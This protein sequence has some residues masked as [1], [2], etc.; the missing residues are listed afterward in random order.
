MRGAPQA[1]GRARGGG[2]ARGAARPGRGAALP[3][4]GKGSCEVA[5][6]RLRCLQLYPKNKQRNDGIHTAYSRGREAVRKQRPAEGMEAP[7]SCSF[8]NR[9]SYVRDTTDVEQDDFPYGG[10]AGITCEYIS[11]EKLSDCACI[12]SISDIFNLSC[13]EAYKNASADYEIHAQPEGVC[14]Y[15]TGTMGTIGISAAMPRSEASF[16][17]ELPGAGGSEPDGKDPLTRS[18]MSRVLLRHFSKG[19]LTSTWQLIECETI[20][21]TSLTESTD[22][23]T[24][25]L[26]T[27]KRVQG[28]LT[29]EQQAAKV[30]EH[31]LERLKAV[32]TGGKNQ[33]L[34][35]ENELVSKTSTSTTAKIGCRQDN[36][37][38]INEYKDTR[39]FQNTE[40]ERYA[41]K[42][43]VRSHELIQDQGEVQRCQKDNHEV[44]SEMK[45]PKMSENN[46]SVPTIEGTNSF[47]TLLNKLATIH[48]IPENQNCFDSTEV[49]NQK[50][51]SIPGLSQQLKILHQ[52][53]FPNA[54]FVI[55]SGDTGTSPDAFTAGT[56]VLL[57]STP[58][59]SEPR[60]PCRTLAS[61]F[62]A[63]GTVE[64][65]SL[66]PPNLLPEITQGEKRSQILKEQTDQLKMK[67]EDFSQ[68]MAQETFLLQDDY[69]ALNELKRHLDALERNYLTAR[70]EHRDLQL[71]YYKDKAVSIGEFDPERKVEGEIFRLGTLLAAIR[72]Q[73]D[74]SKCS[75]APLLPSC[76]S[77]H[78]SYS[79]WESSIVS[80]IADSPEENAFLP[81]NNEGENTSQTSYVIPQK[82]A[83]FSS[84]RG[85]CNPCFHTLHKRAESTYERE[86]DP[87]GKRWLLASKCSSNVTRFFS[88]EGKYEAE[89]LGSHTQGTLS[90]KYNASEESMKGNNIQETKTGIHSIFTERK[91]TDLSDT[92]LSSDSEDISAYHSY[93]SQSDE[94]MKCESYKIFHPRLHRERKGY[95]SRCPRESQSQFKLRN[96]KESVQSCALC[97]N[98]NSGSTSCS[99]KRTPSQKAQTNKQSP[100]VVNRLSESKRS[101][102]SKSAINIRNRNAKDFNINQILNS[103]LDHAIQT[104]NS[105]KKATE[106]MVQ[107]VSEDLAKAARKQL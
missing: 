76:G 74:D 103:T 47:P 104:A 10:D 21:E 96:Y 31:H 22:E 79:L 37:Q 19:E 52:S 107:A 62:P 3:D 80:S 98:K 50:E 61:A 58:G 39:I 102:R 99:Q 83:H 1:A 88:P 68:R 87:L 78:S 17:K 28:P 89:G 7:R 63:A 27:C 65:R 77:A 75:P 44:T 82:N 40:E 97:R 33:N 54:G 43:S 6:F 29:R 91:P 4:W 81:K 41:F 105:L 85:K 18:K 70:E 59:L 69:L 55:Y 93:G 51:T 100:E 12:K 67:V 9:L 5:S 34:L 15:D 13:S 106:R 38:L 45:V 49:A 36:P 71:Q 66:D 2:A 94:F 14:A 101:A 56:S 57:P 84:E 48:S 53:G 42:K 95:K 16:T 46:K 72:E 32:N 73:A 23:A 26:E 24:N 11:S 30:E 92:N 64:A 90:P 60:L 86:T 25:K 8:L 20:P 35:N